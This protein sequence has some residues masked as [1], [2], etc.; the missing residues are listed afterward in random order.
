[1]NPPKPAAPSSAVLRLEKRHRLVA[2]S[3]IT[4]TADEICVD[5]STLHRWLRDDWAFQAAVNAARI[6][7]HWAVQIRLSEIATA[8][9][10]TVARAVAAGDVRASLAVLKGL[11]V[12][13]GR[14]HEPPSADAE[15]LAEAD[16]V[17]E[18]ER[19]SELLL[20]L[21]LADGL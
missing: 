8:A 6:E 1:M 13:D 3:I 19:R 15:A 7:L 9:T 12:L 21:C 11:G 2:G 10:E 20:R 14:F 18:A 17:E 16:R 5:R 4:N